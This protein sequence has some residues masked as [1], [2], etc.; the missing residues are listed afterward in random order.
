MSLAQPVCA[1]GWGWK[2]SRGSTAGTAQT[3]GWARRDASLL[4]AV[5]W[6]EINTRALQSWSWPACQKDISRIWNGWILKNP[7][8]VA[9]ST[10]PEFPHGGEQTHLR[11]VVVWV[12]RRAWMQ[13]FAQNYRWLRWCRHGAQGRAIN[14]VSGMPKLHQHRWALSNGEGRRGDNLCQ[15]LHPAPDIILGKHLI[16]NHRF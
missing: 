15:M 12:S 9:K 3:K 10:T 14:S 11:N 7:R 13:Q 6:M 1:V 5:P 16:T 4:P 2:P 8:E